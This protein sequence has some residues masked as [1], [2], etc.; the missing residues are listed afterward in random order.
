M[1]ILI[2]PPEL[3]EIQKAIESLKTVDLSSTD[4]DDLK[5]ILF[6]IFQGYMVSA[7]HFDPGL[8]LYRGVK[9]DTIPDNLNKLKYPPK[10][11][12][13]I[14]RVNRSGNPVFYCSGARAVPFF[15]LDVKPGD[16]IVISKWKTTEKLMLNK[17]GYTN[18]G[19]SNLNSNRSNPNYGDV[20]NVIDVPTSKSLI[21]DFLAMEFTRIVP[22]GM[23]HLYKISVAIAEKLFLDD[24]FDGLLYPTIA[25]RGN[26]DNL[27]IKS[28]YVDSKKL[29]FQN[30]EFIRIESKQDFNYQVN[31]LDFAN[32]IK[33]DGT[34]EW[35][36][37]RGNW[38]LREKNDELSF[39]V[40]NGM[41]IAKDKNGNIV[42]PE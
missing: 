15:E 31:V 35:K 11:K 22:C 26:A 36:G 6:P 21:D 39:E 33:N 13:G 12:T 34:I 10:E 20:N 3:S 8:V 5:K 18:A 40:E 25:M 1:N 19:F 23:E 37:R 38:V 42:E 24:L 17:V 4:I 29:V 2:K 32:S 7:P 41:W 16:T 28:Q 30:A 14:N 27:A 9:Y